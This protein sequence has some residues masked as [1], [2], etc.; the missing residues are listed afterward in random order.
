VPVKL[1]AAIEPKTIRFREVHL[2]DGAR[3]E[4]R[5]FCSHEQREVPYEE[6]VKGFEVGPDEYVV[7]DQHE[8]AAAAPRSHAIAVEAFVDASAIDPVF[9]ERAYHVGAGKGGGDAYRLLHEALGRSGRAAIG[10]FAFHNREYLAAIRPY[11]R[12]LV[13]HTMRF[14]DEVVPGEEIEVATPQRPPADREIRMAE[15]LVTALHRDFDPSDYSDDHREAVL[16]LIERKVAGERVAAP[17]P[18][19]QEEPGDL[20]AAL[21]ASLAGSR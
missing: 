1:Y 10:R 9:Y 19:P 18:E 2:S 7:L 6:V 3:I 20:V 16:R 13:L 14:V 15:Q 4:H 21:E 8:I 11:G 5:R 12:V 17:E